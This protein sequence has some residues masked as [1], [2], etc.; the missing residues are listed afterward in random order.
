MANYW[1]PAKKLLNDPTKFLDSLLNFDKDNIGDS[2]I[3]KV[4]PYIQVS[5]GFVVVSLLRMPAYCWA[6]TMYPLRTQKPQPY[7][8]LMSR[9]DGGVHP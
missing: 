9:T 4:E 6:T 2:I 5:R 7:T 1:E 8:P 3:K